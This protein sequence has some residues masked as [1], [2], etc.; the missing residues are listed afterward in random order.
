MSILRKKS[1]FDDT[2]D[3]AEYVYKEINSSNIPIEVIMLLF[4]TVFHAS[5]ETE[6]GKHIHVTITYYDPSSLSDSSKSQKVQVHENWSF[7]PFEKPIVLDKR[8]LVKLSNGADPWS[9]SL[10]VSHDSASKLWIKG[11]I[12]QAIHL[13]SFINFEG[14]TKQEHP[15][16]FQVSIMGIG[17]IGVR[18]A[19]GQIAT[20]KRGSLL[21]KFKNVITNGSVAEVVKEISSNTD[22]ELYDDLIKD[23]AD[24]SEYDEYRVSSTILYRNSLKRLLNRIRSYNHGGALLITDVKKNDSLRIKYPLKYPRLKDAIKKYCLNASKEA[25]YQQDNEEERTS[26]TEELWKILDSKKSISKEIK[27]AI[28]FIGSLAGVDGL[29]LMD[30]TGTVNGFGVV[31]EKVQPPEK[32][33]LSN[34]LTP[35]AESLKEIDAKELGT[36]HQSMFSYC[37]SHAGSLGFVISQDGDIRAVLK[38]GNKLIVWENIAVLKTESFR[39]SPPKRKKV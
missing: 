26:L 21:T 23:E 25:M 11:M 36:R 12:D 34:T 8:N 3:L 31:I 17:N 10:A 38:V 4:D 19:S 29:I 22:D 9:S 15:G 6:E 30:K 2:D 20:L 27:G 28:R 13:E 24:L 39:P 5:M 16:I 14:E 32:I 18:S 37:N 7:V 35:T 1:S 33:Y